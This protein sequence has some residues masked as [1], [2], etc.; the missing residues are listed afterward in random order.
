MN[1]YRLYVLRRGRAALPAVTL[2]II[3]AHLFVAC[4]IIGG[5]DGDG[6]EEAY[7]APDAE[8]ELPVA[9]PTLTCSQ[10]CADRGQCGESADRGRVVLLST[11]EPGVSPTDFDLAVADGAAV[12][13][14]ETRPV[15]VQ[16]TASGF[17]FSVD[18]YR[19]LVQDRNVEGWVAGWC[20]LNP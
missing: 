7:P 12:S 15:N 6:G 20:V 16:E 19:V 11:N 5:G 4:S 14:L 8:S 13:V 2:L 18:F 17:E 10:E 1:Q 9:G 3:F